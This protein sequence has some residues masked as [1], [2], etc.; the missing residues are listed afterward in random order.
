MA[1]AEL[2]ETETE[3]KERL[4]RRIEA[5]HDLDRLREVFTFLDENDVYE[6]T[7]EEERILDEAEKD[8]E[9][10]PGEEAA[11]RTRFFLRSLCRNSD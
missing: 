3:L 2:I 7:P 10:I 9:L 11:R 1:T 6:L 8:T 4:I 5:T